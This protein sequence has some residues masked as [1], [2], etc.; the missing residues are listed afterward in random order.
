[1]KKSISN[2]END[3][4]VPFIDMLERV[5]DYFEV[6]TDYLLGHEDKPISGVSGVYMLDDTG[7]NQIRIVHIE[8]SV[9]GIRNH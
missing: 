1:M 5:A 7:L 6:S 8:T 9:N 2:W 3:K 4:I